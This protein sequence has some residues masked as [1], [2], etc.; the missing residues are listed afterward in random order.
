MRCASTS[1]K[2]SSPA[3]CAAPPAA[4][5]LYSEDDV[6]W[7]RLCILLRSSGM[8]LPS[9]RRYTELVRQ[10]EG[11]EQERLALLRQHEEQVV[12]QI[13]ELN[14]CLDV[15]RYKVAKYEDHPR[16]P[17]LTKIT[18]RVMMSESTA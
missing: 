12:S 14:R 9:I 10:G 13:D 11:N 4:D 6:E 3:R 5:A 17:G 16:R 1:A 15:I 18:D 2:A 8:P 7:L